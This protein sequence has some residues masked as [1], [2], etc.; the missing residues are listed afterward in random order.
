MPYLSPEDIDCDDFQDPEE[1]GE[2]AGDDEE[3]EL[4]EDNEIILN[5]KTNVV[6]T[7]GDRLTKHLPLSKYEITRL[8]NERIAELI[9][10]SAPMLGPEFQHLF[11]DSLKTARLEYLTC[12]KFA[13]E[14]FVVR[15]HLDGSSE[16][17]A[18]TEFS[19]FPNGLKPKYV[20]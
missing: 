2:V 20:K 7:G 8:L 19:H 10:D 9:L 3:Q 5:K 17:W 15:T 1:A 12:P 11:R 14:F 13:E 4:D 6:L 16:M 18:I